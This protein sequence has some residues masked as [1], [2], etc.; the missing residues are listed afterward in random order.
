MKEGCYTMKL[1]NM[2]DAKKRDKNK[3]VIN[4]KY[5]NVKIDK[6]EYERIIRNNKIDETLYNFSRKKMLC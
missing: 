4:Y 5:E 2:L 6:K 1:P 3:E